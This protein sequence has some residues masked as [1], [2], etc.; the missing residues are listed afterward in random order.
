[1]TAPPACAGYLA[2]LTSR[3]LSAHTLA[4]TARDLTAL[5]AFCVERRAM[6]PEHIDTHLLRAWLAALRGRGLSPASVRRMLCSA[7]GWL[8][9]EA[10]CNRLPNNPAQGL[11]A[12]KGRREL[13]KSV[14]A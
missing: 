11:R 1:M 13:P 3:R 10:Q 8:R 14:D 5:C 4:A 2:E 12:P 9:F 6:I 7:R